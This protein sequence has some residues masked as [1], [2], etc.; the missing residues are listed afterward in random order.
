VGREA[1]GAIKRSNFD[2]RF[3]QALRSGIMLVGDKV[4]VSL[5]IS[6]L[7]R[8]RVA[9]RRRSHLYRLKSS[10]HRG[11]LPHRPPP[12]GG[13]R[14]ARPA[15]ADGRRQVMGGDGAQT[16]RRASSRTSAFSLTSNASTSSGTPTTAF[17]GAGASC[18][19]ASYRAGSRNA[20]SAS[21][22]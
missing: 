19:R 18:R 5:D 8:A 21:G 15:T 11:W 20:G 3:N 14:R 22:W 13:G 1:V 2:M 4:T 6:A 17:G 10:T 9:G 7:K 16:R 12:N